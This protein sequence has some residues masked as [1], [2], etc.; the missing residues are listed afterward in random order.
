MK[1][2]IQLQLRRKEAH[3]ELVITGPI[4]SQLFEL[5]TQQLAREIARR[6][7]LIKVQLHI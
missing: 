4:L 2:A 1:D 3:S 7:M 6:K 5:N